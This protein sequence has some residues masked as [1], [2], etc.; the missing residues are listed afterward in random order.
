MK[1]L[2]FLLIL[3]FIPFIVLAEKCDISKITITSMEQNSIE[4]N[5]EVISEPTFRDRSI[6]LNLKMYD[7]GDSITYN[8]T[9]KNDSDEDYMIDEDTFK[10]DSDYIEYILSTEDNSNVVK[11]N[12][13]KNMTLTVRYKNEIDQALL[14]N[15]KYNASNNLKLSMNTSEKEKE[16]EVITTD[17]IKESKNPVKESNNNTKADNPITSD[18]IKLIIVILLTVIAIIFLTIINKKKYNKYL[19]LVL[20]FILLPIVYAVC[21]CD[22]EVNANIQIINPVVYPEGKSKETVVIGDIVKIGTEEF[23]VVSNDGIDLVLLAHYNLKVGN[24]YDTFNHK[25]GEYTNSDE[26][27]GRQS[28]EALGFVDSPVDYKYYGTIGFSNTNY[29]DGKI[30]TDY[31]G[32]YCT[33]NNINISNCAYIYDSNS[34]LYQYIESYKEYLESLEVKIKNARLLK[35]EEAV[36]LGCIGYKSCKSSPATAPSW[37]YE[38]SY[39]L[40]SAFSPY[41]TWRVNTRGY[42]YPDTYSYERNHGVRPVIVV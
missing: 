12:S 3:L 23:Y 11:A 14:T 28:S 30:G 31:L 39:W 37:I 33:E 7:V 41:Y 18:N 21:S 8:M 15:N 9:I 6:S 16:L 34:N 13:N 38:T 35:V 25:E 20:S 32:S 4:G 10:T 22:I 42:F 24:I 36:E 40:G 1:Y 19:I 2:K 27:Y 26:G 29:W 17:N 5:T